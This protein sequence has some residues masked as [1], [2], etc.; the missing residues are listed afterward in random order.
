MTCNECGKYPVD[1]PKLG[2]CAFCI[3]ATIRGWTERIW[4]NYVRILE[5]VTVNEQGE[6][7]WPDGLS[8]KGI[9][10]LL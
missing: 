6:W 4:T 3:N 5:A 10:M 2:I 7:V 8:Q 1:I 9:W